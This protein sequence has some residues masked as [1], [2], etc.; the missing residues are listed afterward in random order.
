MLLVQ[1]FLGYND[2]W[3]LR[4][5]DYN[6]DNEAS[7]LADDCWDAEASYWLLTAEIPKPLIGWWRSGDEVSDWLISTEVPMLLIGCLL[8]RC[9]CLWLAVYCWGAEAPDWPFN[10]TEVPRRLIIA[11]VPR[12]LIIWWLLRCRGRWLAVDCSGA[13]ACD[14]LKTAEEPTPLIG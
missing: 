12:P 9:R 13:E 14:W 10:S 1:S 6:W 4:L 11:V 3:G 2:C 8:L 7:W 5:D